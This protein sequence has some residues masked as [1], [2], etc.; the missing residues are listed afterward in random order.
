MCHQ[1]W[2]LVLR[3]YSALGQ[4]SLPGG[5]PHISCPPKTFNSGPTHPCIP[6]ELK[7]PFSELKVPGH[8]VETSGPLYEQAVMG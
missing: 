2:V 5:N 3:G 8:T 6:T 1:K 4:L 7:V